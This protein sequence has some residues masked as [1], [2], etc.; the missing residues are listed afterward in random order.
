MA[1][2]DQ[3]P[4][5]EFAVFIGPAQIFLNDARVVGNPRQLLCASIVAEFVVRQPD[6]E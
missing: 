4:D 3:M 6:I 2:H 1:R 5:D